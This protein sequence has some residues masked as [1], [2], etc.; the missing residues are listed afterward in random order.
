MEF[1]FRNWLY[2]TWLSGDHIVEQHVHNIDVANWVMGG[3][4]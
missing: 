2:Y 1:Q 4:R 3:I